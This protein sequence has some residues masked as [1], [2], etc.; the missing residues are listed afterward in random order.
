MLRAVLN[1]SMASKSSVASP[2]LPQFRSI[3]G[4]DSVKDGRQENVARNDSQVV[5]ERAAGHALGRQSANRHRTHLR[6]R[7]FDFHPVGRRT[8]P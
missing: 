4:S 8:G 5:G 3:G 6:H 1:D 7:L 2:K